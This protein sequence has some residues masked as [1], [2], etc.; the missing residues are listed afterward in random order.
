MWLGQGEEQCACNCKG[1]L[2]R[3]WADCPIA[4]LLFFQCCLPT[5]GSGLLKRR[6]CL[7]NLLCLARSCSGYL[8]GHDC[9]T[10]F[11]VFSFVGTV[12]R[13]NLSWNSLSLRLV[14]LLRGNPCKNIH[15]HIHT[16]KHT[17]AFILA[18]H[19]TH[20]DLLNSKKLSL[21]NSLLVSE[22]GHL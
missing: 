8:H 3:Q 15:I 1:L 6:K 20:H 21:N 5:V 22:V 7:T 17:H 2:L 16:N 10:T 13:W 14:A 9:C 4:N 18:H 12:L 19:S 11:F